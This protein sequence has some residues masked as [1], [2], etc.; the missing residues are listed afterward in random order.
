M[1][2]RSALLVLSLLTVSP[3]LAVETFHVLVFTR[4][5]GFRHASIPNGIALVQA[6]GEQH[7][8]A[9]DATEDATTFTEAA[10]HRRLRWKRIVEIDEL[11]RGVSIALGDQ[12]LEACTAVDANRDG[13]VTIEEL[14]RSVNIALTACPAR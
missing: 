1:K 8:F 5:A 9:V 13:A 2:L 3:A 4:T 10:L 14:V 6:L 11:V 12:S 7:N